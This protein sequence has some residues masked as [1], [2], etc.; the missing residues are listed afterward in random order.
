MKFREH[1]GGYAE[2]MATAVELSTKEEFLAHLGK[3]VRKYTLGSATVRFRDMELADVRDGWRLF[4]VILDG[5]GP[6]GMMDGPPPT[7]WLPP[8][9]FV[10]EEA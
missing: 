4:Y 2:S 3:I 1:K 7:A 6:I 8:I 9:E 5:Y 10:R